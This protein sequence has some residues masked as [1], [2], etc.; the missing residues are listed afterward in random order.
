MPWVLLALALV[1]VIMMIFFSLLSEEG[2]EAWILVWG[3]EPAGVIQR[4]L[5]GPGSWLS[6][7][8]A[9]LMTALVVHAGW[10]HLLGNLAYLWVFGIPV[11]RVLGHW[12]FALCFIL[13]GGFANLSVAWQLADMTTPVIGASGGISAVVGVYL[14]LFPTSRM[15]LWLPLGLYLQFAR[16]PGVL[17]IGSWF[18]LQLLYTVFGPVSGAV[19]WWTHVAGFL[20][21]LAFALLLRAC[22][23]GLN[24]RIVGYR[25]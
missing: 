10:L 9:G 4:L 21:G 16:I 24:R 6:A 7:E 3:F 23:P 22:A 19:A 13:L 8:M 25:T 18:I 12:A 11:E 20:A 15:G 17:V 2:Q 1:S 5:E 14:G